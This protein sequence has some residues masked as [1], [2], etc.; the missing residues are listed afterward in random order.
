ML[1]STL[2]SKILTYL[3][4][5]SN[6]HAIKTVITNH[7]GT[8]DVLVCYKGYFIYIEIKSPS[9]PPRPSAIQ[10]YII[11]KLQTAGA[12]GFTTNNYTHF[13]ETY[14]ALIMSL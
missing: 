6:T 10:Q 9:Q 5:Q 13:L 1:E 4:K 3:S 8:P 14:N 12:R 7:R 11:T 2:Q